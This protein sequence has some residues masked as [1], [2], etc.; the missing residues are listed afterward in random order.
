M[1]AW[2]IQETVPFVDKCSSNVAIKKRGLPIGEYLIISYPATDVVKYQI[3]NKITGKPLIPTIFVDAYD[4]RNT[5]EWFDKTY[6]DYFPIWEEYPE[7]DIFK[8]SQ[9]SV[10]NG[11]NLFD[12]IERLK[13]QKIFDKSKKD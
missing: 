6:G 7:A 4:V 3:F 12:L 9:W 2:T 10:K 5:A 8:M 13:K 11:L 1:P